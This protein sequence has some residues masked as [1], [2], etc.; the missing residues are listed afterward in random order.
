MAWWPTLPSFLFL[1][2]MLFCAFGLCLL[3]CFYAGDR[4]GK[5]GLALC[6]WGLGFFWCGVA[7]HGAMADR[8]PTHDSFDPQVSDVYWVEGHVVGLPT[9]SDS[10]L[11]FEF[12]TAESRY[13]N[14][15]MVRW[16]RPNAYITSGQRWSLPLRIEAPRGRLNFGGFDYERYLLAQGI[17]GLARISTSSQN[18]PVFLGHKDSLGSFFSRHRQVLAENIQATTTSL[19]VA[20]LKRALLIG[21]RSAI[22]NDVREILQRTGTAHLLAISGLHVGMVAGLGMAFGWC[23]WVILVFLKLRVSRRVALVATGWLVGFFYAG[24]AGFSLPT[25]RAVLMLGV[26]AVALIWERRIMPFDA[27]LMAAL[28]V[29]MLSPLAV[30][31]VGFWLSFLAVMFLIWGFAWRIGVRTHLRGVRALAAAQLI[32]SVGLL[33]L[34]VGFFGQL[35]SSAFLANLVAIPWVG[36][37]VLPSLLLA[38]ITENIGWSVPLIAPTGD[39]AL[40]WLMSFLRWL[41]E[42]DWS[43]QT[44]S[45]Q[46]PSAMVLALIGAIW[47]LAPR[48]W[49]GRWLGL[50]LMAPLLLGALV[51]SLNTPSHSSGEDLALS[52]LDVGSGLAVMAETG[53]YRLLFDTGP[54]DGLGRDSIGDS[55]KHWPRSDGLGGR[56]LIID[57]LV[58]SHAH[59]GHR[60]GLG[61]IDQWAWARRAYAPKEMRLDP[62]L[63]IGDVIS[64]HRGH[65]W[66]EGFWTFEFVHPGQ[67]LPDLAGN[68]GCVLWIYSESTSVVLSGGLDAIGEAHVATMVPELQ[69]DIV[70]IGRSG[71]QD[72]TSQL[73]LEQLNPRMAVISVSGSDSYGRPAEGVLKRLDAFGVQVLKTSQCHAIR[74]LMNPTDSQVQVATVVGREPRFWR[75]GADC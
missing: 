56:R 49:P 41:S 71:H 46:S 44:L 53:R 58:L 14:R 60:G 45:L 59:R 39:L 17:G 12:V 13:P 15:L 43:H 34:N 2:V 48:G 18:E 26:A 8:W 66:V 74:L 68:S 61:A 72:T 6:A 69:A 19:E 54:G 38:N 23:V 30:L 29:L 24:L 63:P 67:F 73:W 51:P 37:V 64:C 7:A 27:V 75:D 40:A 31:S 10:T 1:V 62:L 20:A 57:D 35:S 4:G 21:D 36:S 65:K 32:L 5:L 52:V 11:R 3:A 42:M 70:V 28:V 55:L 33:P 50:G 16:Y 25:Q 47:L 22:S 9:W